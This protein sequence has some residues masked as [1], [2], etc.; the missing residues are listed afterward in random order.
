VKPPAE[1]DNLF[2]FAAEGRKRCVWIDHLNI[3]PNSGRRSHIRTT[4]HCEGENTPRGRTNAVPGAP[5]PCDSLSYQK[6]LVYRRENVWACGR[7]GGSNEEIITLGLRE[8]RRSMAKAPV[9]GSALVVTGCRVPVQERVATI[10]G[11]IPT[12]REFFVAVFPWGEKRPRSVGDTRSASS[13]KGTVQ[14]PRAPGRSYETLGSSGRFTCFCPCE[15]PIR[16]FD[17]SGG[18]CRSG[19]SF[20]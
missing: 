14:S 16:G 3:C 17:F 11:R 2:H 8:H 10:F 12:H 13:A 4:V 20:W 19:K 7:V 18:G 15:K 6:S 5:E 9:P 1:L